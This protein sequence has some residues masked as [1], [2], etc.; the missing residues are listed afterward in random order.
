[1]LLEH[2]WYGPNRD[3]FVSTMAIGGIDGKTLKRR[4]TDDLKGRV[5]AKTGYIRGVSCLSGFL[6]AQ[7]GSTLAFSVLINDIYTDDARRLQERIVK[8]VDRN[9]AV[10]SSSINP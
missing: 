7:D 10:S 4:F 3:T 2:D 8:V 6:K 1:M 9:S 5:F